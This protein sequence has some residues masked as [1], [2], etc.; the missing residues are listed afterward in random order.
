MRYTIPPKPC[1]VSTAFEKQAIFALKSAHCKYWNQILL[2]CTFSFAMEIVF[3]VYVENI[4]FHYQNMIL[5]RLNT[6]VRTWL[7]LRK[8]ELFPVTRNT[9]ERRC[10]LIINVNLFIFSFQ[11]GININEQLSHISK[12]RMIKWHHSSRYGGL[13]VIIKG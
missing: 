8:Q 13:T 12:I 2:S 10:K 1:G 6:S 5:D 7:V 4:V 9:T 3:G 11:K